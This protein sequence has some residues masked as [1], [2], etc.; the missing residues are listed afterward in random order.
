MFF[1]VGKCSWGCYKGAELEECHVAL[2]T[3]V[4]V[5]QSYE[6]AVLHA[7]RKMRLRC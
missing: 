6:V 2:L 7:T 3:V 1:A 5:E 4:S